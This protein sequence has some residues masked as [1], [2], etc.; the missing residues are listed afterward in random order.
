[1]EGFARAAVGAGAALLGGLVLAGCGSSRSPVGDARSSPP[2]EKTHW[3]AVPAG[4]LPTHRV[5]LRRSWTPTALTQ[6][7]DRVDPHRGMSVKAVN[8]RHVPPG[9]PRGWW[10]V[11]NDPTRNSQAEGMRDYWTAQIVGRLYQARRELPAP[12]LSGIE[13][14]TQVPSSS[15]DWAAGENSHWWGRSART[16]AQGRPAALRKNVRR[17]AVDLGLKLS[18]FRVPRL[19]GLVAPVVTLQVS[20][21]ARF[22]R[23][24]VPGCAE[25][26]MLGPRANTDGSPYFGFFLTVDD[27]AGNWLGSTAATPNSTE[28]G[29]SAAM[30]ELFPPHVAPGQVGGISACPTRFR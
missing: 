10:F 28:S 27:S 11:W 13:L 24:Y 25:G 14:K 3:V 4:L 29:E 17:R 19:D 16:Y 8:R 21:E 22:K 5:E 18:S 7:T 9:N 12:K 20:D 2:S 15:S 30:H 23:W 26:W 6:I 1:M